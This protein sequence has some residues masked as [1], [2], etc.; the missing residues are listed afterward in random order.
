MLRASCL[1][2][3]VL[4]ALPAAASAKSPRMYTVSPVRDIVD[5]SALTVSGAAIIEVEH[6]EVVVTASRRTVKRL[7]R[8][9]FTVQ[10]M[11][12]LR[13]LRPVAQL[14]ETPGHWARPSVP[15]G[16]HRPVWPT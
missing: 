5:R 6:A 11:H 3:L 4:V 12:P 1:A 2:V 7:R 13:H 9:G 15:L 16:Y 8:K 14:S 10:R